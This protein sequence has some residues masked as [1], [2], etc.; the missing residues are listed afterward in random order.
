[1]SGEQRIRAFLF[2][3]SVLIFFAGLPFI[4]SSAL[5]YKFDRRSLKFTKT[6]LIVLKTQPTGA[7][8]FLDRAQIN[9]K[10]P[11]SINELLP[12]RYFLDVQL[13]GYYPYVA[14]VDVEAGKVT[15]LEKILLFPQRPDIKKLNKEI[16]SDFWLDEQKALLYYLNE[17][18]QV[19]YRSDLDGGHFEKVMDF[20]KIVPPA[21]KWRLS[22]DKEKLV[23]FNQHQ[24]GI[25]YLE[26]Q[27]QLPQNQKVF[28]INYPN[29]QIQ[30]IFW[31][32]D[33]FHLIVVAH[34][35]IDT[36]EAITSASPLTLAS[37][38]KKNSSVSYDIRTDTLY[39]LDVQKAPDG[40][41]YDNL[42]KLELNTRLYPFKDFIKLAP[43]FEKEEEQPHD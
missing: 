42:Y 9:D 25:M 11:T 18:E 19:L 38:N 7:T 5:G 39:F 29:A 6:G 2:Y 8:V 21:E 1:M 31:H 27:R 12:G 40:K 20:I 30:D 13:E 28:V 32:S 33:S 34:N 37:R 24:I 41:P 36:L 3:L 10:T 16:I 14:E 4:L 35:K 23:Y 26:Q 43:S 17:Q 15:R 22:P